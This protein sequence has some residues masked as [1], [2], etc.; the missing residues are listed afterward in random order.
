MRLLESDHPRRAGL[1]RNGKPSNSH[2]MIH[3]RVM[4]WGL[5]G[6]I[7]GFIVLAVIGVLF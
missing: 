4:L 3:V 5:A 2:P 7:L 6:A 1:R